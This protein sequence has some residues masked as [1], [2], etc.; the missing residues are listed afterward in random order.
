MTALRTGLS[1]KLDNP[2]TELYFPH[3]SLKVLILWKGYLFTPSL[4]C[5]IQMPKPFVVLDFQVFLLYTEC[6]VVHRC[7]VVR[8]CSAGTGWTL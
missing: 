4:Q 1:F 6:R 5:R 7:R 3:L 8:R 2:L